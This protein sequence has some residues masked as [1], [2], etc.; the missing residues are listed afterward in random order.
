MGAY[1]APVLLALTGLIGSLY[2]AWVQLRTK[3]EDGQTATGKLLDERYQ[4]LL[5]RLTERVD[6][7]EAQAKE[8]RL[9]I[10]TLELEVA[11][12]R[13]EN[14]TLRS[15]LARLT[16]LAAGVEADTGDD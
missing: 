8:D 10:H 3:R 13:A 16:R 2:A 7:L 4:R 15:Q 14:T 9:T 5:D 12:L 1:V 11:T 6:E